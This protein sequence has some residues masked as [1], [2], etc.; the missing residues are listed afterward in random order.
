MGTFAYGRTDARSARHTGCGAER[1]ADGRFVVG[2]IPAWTAAKPEK[3][4]SSLGYS[5]D[6][7][8]P[9]CWRGEGRAV[10]FSR[11]GHLAQT[12]F[13]KHGQ[14]PRLHHSV[15]RVTHRAIDI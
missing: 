11:L 1:K 4:C 12:Q 5:L 3:L 6:P 10:G 15:S 2:A 13:N 7:L 8:R 9:P 14:R